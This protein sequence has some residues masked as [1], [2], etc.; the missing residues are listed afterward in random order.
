VPTNEP[1]PTKAQRRDDAR[2]KALAMRK[3]QE[4]RA[5]RNR[6]IGITVLVVAV[7]GLGAAGFWITKQNQENT[8]SGSN[9]VYGGDSS[10]VVAPALS[11][12][13]APSTANDKGGIPVSKDGVG[14]AGDDDV[15][16]AVYFDLQCPYCQHFDAAN[17]SDLDT[18]A[19]SGDVTVQYHPI[20]FLN[21][22][23]LGTNYSTRAANAVAIVA[24]KAPEK[25]TAFVTKL[26]DNQPAEQTKGLSDA[27]IAE[28]AQD[29]GV[30]SSVTDTFADTVKGSYQT[31]DSSGATTSHDGEW[32]TFAP[33]IAAATEQASTDMGG[34][35]GT[36]F[37]TI[38]GKEFSGD[39]YTQGPLMQ[40]V[41]AAVA[42][43][44]G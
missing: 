44:K 18:M 37:V 7:L 34:K 3:E 31:K 14:K 15:V 8:I 39:L 23:S 41:Q 43:K 21:D 24:D 20:S 16:V 13:T 33:W 27:K 1:R 36:P 42:A 22:S 35:L 4:R 26:Y 9:V 17:A 2:A 29:A 40:Q 12:V 6:I 28:I 5:K 32:R 30:P 11:D 10:N 19:A 38:D 25:F